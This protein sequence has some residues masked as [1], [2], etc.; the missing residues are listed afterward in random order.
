MTIPESVHLY[1]A[2]WL[3]LTSRWNNMS[4]SVAALVSL[5]AWNYDDEVMCKCPDKSEAWGKAIVEAT[6]TAKLQGGCECLINQWLNFKDKF[7]KNGEATFFFFSQN[8]V[9]FTLDI[10]ENTISIVF[11]GTF[12]LSESSLSEN[13]TEGDLWIIQSRAASKLHQIS[14]RGLFWG[15]I[16]GY[17]VRL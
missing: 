8:N 7:E 1:L 12:S 15:Q 11:I 16:I 3:W 2:V 5:V 13:C 10:S 17:C 9:L 14:F 6:A 4:C